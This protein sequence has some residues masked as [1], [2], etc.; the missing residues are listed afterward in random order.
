MA[1]TTACTTITS[2]DTLQSELPSR[3]SSVNKNFWCN[4]FLQTVS[5][6]YD[7]LPWAKFGTE[8]NNLISIAYPGDP[9]PS[10]P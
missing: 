9:S 3:L 2:C 6:N 5:D 1:Y 10:T 7:G 4:D 8:V